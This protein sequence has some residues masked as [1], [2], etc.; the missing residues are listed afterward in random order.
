M[1]RFFT[2]FLILCF[3]AFLRFEN[4]SPFKYYPDAY[5]NLLVA[6]NIKTYKSVVGFLGQEGMLY[7]DFVMWS[8]PVY[9]LLINIT[10][11]LI[12][13]SALAAHVI[14]F[15]MGVAAIPLAFFLAK[16]IFKSFAVG[17]AAAFLLSLSFLHTLWSGSIMT[18]T[19][20]VFFIMLFLWRLFS[21][22]ESK[23]K[24]FDLYDFLIGAIFGVAVLTRYEYIFLIVPTVILLILKSPSPYL[25]I[26]NIIVSFFL[27]VAVCLSQ[28]FPLQSSLSYIVSQLE[29]MLIL[30]GF[31]LILLTGISIGSYLFFRSSKNIAT[32]LNLVIAGI[33][34]ILGIVLVLQFINQRFF[35]FG[36]YDFTSL[37][38]FV[39]DDML[40]AFTF[41]IGL[42]ILVRQSKYKAPVLFV[43][44]SLFGMYL[45]YHRINPEMQRYI[46]HLLPFLIIPASYGLYVVVKTIKRLITSESVDKKVYGSILFVFFF[47]LTV[48]QTITTFQG[49]TYW[50]DGSWIR[51]S[52]E[53]KAARMVA[54]K[55]DK[56]TILI[57]SFPEPYYYFAKVS[58]QS[59]ADTYPFV[60]IDGALDNRTVLIVQDMGMH[61]VFPAFSKF[62]DTQLQKYRQDSFWAQES[63]HYR[64]R[65]EKEK[66]PVIL[67]RI[68]LSE[69][70]EII[71][72]Y[73]I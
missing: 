21:S 39:R 42:T 22:L 17:F 20:G 61:D 29:H 71:K 4:V 25:R 3:G 7:P 41:L 50:S 58:T 52:Y 23:A 44:V 49:I 14:S 10:S 56:N 36:Y 64:T 6:E 13:D 26:L 73:I 60:F 35:P 66:Y 43:I 34:W 32:R 1:I 54:E 27:V 5:Q 19:T 30:A 12:E 62:L 55:I 47:A 8:R 59:I 57:A 53:E 24:L 16:S 46:T 28:L 37:R 48:K 45:I 18:E 67:Y 33:F 65:I 51:A 38:S 70:K 15:L 11:F 72:K 63:Y 31:I 68:K 69:L 9:P 2:V 40:I